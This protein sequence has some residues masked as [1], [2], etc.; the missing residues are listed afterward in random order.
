[1]SVSAKLVTKL[2]LMRIVLIGTTFGIKGVVQ[3]PFGEKSYIVGLTLISWCVMSY[4]WN[5]VI[6]FGKAHQINLHNNKSRDSGGY[7]EKAQ[8]ALPTSSDEEQLVITWMQQFGWEV[9]DPFVCLMVQDAKIP[10]L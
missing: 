8:L 2:G 3:I 9:G 10:M 6:P 4:I 7:L 5:Q 1:M